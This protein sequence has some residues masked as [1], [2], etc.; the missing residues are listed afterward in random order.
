MP[1]DRAADRVRLRRFTF[2]A[3]ITNVG[4]VFSGGLVRVTGSGLG[5]PRW[6]S[7]DGTDLVPVPGGDHGGWQA[8]LEF[9]NRLLTFVVLAAAVAVLI[10]VHRTR[11]HSRL[12]H[13]AAWALPIGVVVQALLGGVTV[14]TSLTPIMVATH[15]LVS[16]VLIALAVVL[17]EHAGNPKPTGDATAIADVVRRATTVLAIVAAVVLLLGTLV[18][19]SGPHG[20]DV[21]APRLPFDIRLV[22][23]AHADAV[24]MLLG[25]TVLLVVAT[26]RHGPAPLRTAIRVLLGI[27]IAQ[28][29]IGYTQYV[30]GVP[31]VLVAAHILGA[32]LLW[33]AVVTVWIRARL[34]GASAV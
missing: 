29:M 25:V 17:H 1:V 12:V 7:C 2:A 9:G 18:T 4:I 23:I 22:A 30:L 16:M 34:G 10:E 15:F 13:R 6:P 33:T 19:G 31:P 20:G 24:W 3:I 32:A 11:P 27:E 5:C 21:D 8:A 14:L 26:W 28:G